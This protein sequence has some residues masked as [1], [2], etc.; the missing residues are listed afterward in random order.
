M[1]LVLFEIVGRVQFSCQLQIYIDLPSTPSFRLNAIMKRGL[2]KYKDDFLGRLRDLDE[3][4]DPFIVKGMY[5]D[6]RAQLI[7]AYEDS[8]HISFCFAIDDY[9]AGAPHGNH[10]YQ[11]FNFDKR[12]GR[13]VTFADLFSVETPEDSSLICELIKAS[14]DEVGLDPFDV[15]E[16]DFNLNK[17]YVVFNFDAYEIASYGFGSTEKHCS[18]VSEMIDNNI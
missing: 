7:S 1:R 18:R 15:Y 3:D 13:E 12:T 2:S 17:G 5:S 6:F 16:Y 9:L 8:V 11:S 14:V 4:V 10:Y